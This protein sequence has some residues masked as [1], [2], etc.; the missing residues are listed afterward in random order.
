[1][2]G[3][4]IDLS[5]SGYGSVTASYD[6]ANKTSGCTKCEKIFW[7][8]ADLWTTVP[9]IFICMMQDSILFYKNNPH[10]VPKTAQNR[11]SKKTAMC[12]F[13]TICRTW[14]NFTLRTTR[15]IWKRQWGT[16]KLVYF[17]VTSPAN[18]IEICTAHPSI[19]TQKRWVTQ[20]YSL[21]LKGIVNWQTQSLL[22]SIM[23]QQMHLYIIK[24]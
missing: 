22:P 5:V 11:V 18:F 8:N 3:C 24:H 15:Y 10:A 6:Q 12:Y 17:F 16:N 13:V 19:S 21:Y 9:H 20:I 14:L 4:K 1:M 2:R 7:I 23:V